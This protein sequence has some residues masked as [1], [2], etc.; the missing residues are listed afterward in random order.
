MCFL[1]ICL[2]VFYL[3][4]FVIFSLPLG[5][6]GWLLFVIVSFLSIYPFDF[7][8]RTWILA[9]L[10]RRLTGELIGQVKCVHEALRIPKVKVFH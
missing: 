6:G 5:V 2:F 3:L 1:C 8:V 4:V 9:H 10:G 7:Q